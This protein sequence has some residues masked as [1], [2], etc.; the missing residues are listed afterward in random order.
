MK[1]SIG[2]TDF[3][4][5]KEIYDYHIFLTVQIRF[6][7]ANAFFQFFVDILTLGSSYFCESVSRKPKCGGSNGSGSVNK[8]VLSC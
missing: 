6:L 7:R 1:N 8:Y 4:N 5:R 2:F 3:F